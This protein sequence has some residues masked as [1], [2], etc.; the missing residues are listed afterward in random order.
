MDETEK[1]SEVTPTEEKTAEQ[2]AVGAKTPE[3]PK[4]EAGPKKQPNWTQVALIALS[5]A[6]VLLLASTIALAVTGNFGNGGRGGRGGCIQQGQGPMMR[7]NG[8]GFRNQS[9]PPFPNKDGPMMQRRFRQDQAP[10][11]TPSAPAPQQE[12]PTPTPTQ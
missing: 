11:S 5:V 2:P 7:G 10:Q 4:A 9:E 1:G 6:V 12:A 8:R 3:P